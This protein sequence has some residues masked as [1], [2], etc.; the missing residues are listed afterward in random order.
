MVT[1]AGVPA[2]KVIVG[3][4]SYGRSF[5]M[6][7]KSC[8]G[9]S[10]SFTGSANVSNAEPGWCTGTGGYISN[11]EIREILLSAEQGQPGY[12]AESRWDSKSNSDI[13]TYGTLGKGMADWVSYMD[14]FT[15]ENRVSWYKALN[16]GGTTDWAIDLDDW[17]LDTETDSYD[18]FTGVNLECDSTNWPTTLET[19]EAGIDAIGP[20]CRAMAT[21]RVLINALKSA[22]AEYEDAT[23]GFDDLVRS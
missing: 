9:P 21:T 4:S 2:S 20:H 10:C 1:K 19:L 14:G 11:A 18:N 6:A 3:I 12:E 13:M 17:Y 16:F 7:D 23:S 15:K 5:Q 8:T 22:L